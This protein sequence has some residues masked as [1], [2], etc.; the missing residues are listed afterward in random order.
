MQAGTSSVRVYILYIGTCDSTDKA[1]VLG[2]HGATHTAPHVFVL[3]TCTCTYIG[4]THVHMYVC[5]QYTCIVHTYACTHVHYMGMYTCTVHGYVHMYVL[6]MGMYTCSVHMYACTF[7]HM[8]MYTST[9]VHTCTCMS[10]VHSIV[11]WCLYCMGGVCTCNSL[12]FLNSWR[13]IRL[14]Q[15]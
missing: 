9:H 14:C 15:L 4:G 1:S 13:V 2:C 6:Y 12:L 3:H 8:Y 7:I 10:Q 5:T 11:H